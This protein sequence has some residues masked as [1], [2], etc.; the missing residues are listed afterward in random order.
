MGLLENWKSKKSELSS[1][2]YREDTLG[3]KSKPLDLVGC[4]A[5]IRKCGKLKETWCPVEEAAF[6]WPSLHF[7]SGKS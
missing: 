3:I 4:K 2:F 5:L 7:L 6:T 1:V